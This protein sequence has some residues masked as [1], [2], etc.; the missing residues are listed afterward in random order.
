[1]LTN[2]H[3]HTKRCKHAIGEDEDYVITA[4]NSG[5][6]ALG[7]SDHAP[8][9]Y[10]DGYVSYYKMLPA[11]A[12]E[13]AKSIFSLREKYRDKIQI[14]LGFEAEY[15]PDIFSN[16][17]KLWREVGAEYIILGQHFIENEY[18]K[19]EH[20]FGPTNNKKLT[21]YVDRCIEAIETEKFSYIAHPDVINYVGEDTAFYER[22]VKRLVECASRNEIPL[23]INLLGLYEGRHYPSKAFWR[24]ASSFKPYVILGSDAHIPAALENMNVRRQGEKLAADFGLKLIDKFEFRPL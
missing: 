19:E 5:Y 6:C 13:Y 21:R 12:D 15:Y 10:K 4:I 14:H 11:D 3:T 8:F 24:A 1:M 2:Y 18:S 22:E 23:E 20:A 7:F 9:D 16:G 17:L